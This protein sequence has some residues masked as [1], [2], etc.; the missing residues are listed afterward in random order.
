PPARPR[1]RRGAGVARREPLRRRDRAVDARRSPARSQRP[2]RRGAARGGAVEARDPAHARPAPG[3]GAPGGRALLLR[4]HDAERDRPRA[5]HLRV[6]R[7]PGPQPGDGPH[8]PAPHQGDALG[9]RP[10]MTPPPERSRASAP[11]ERRSDR[12]AGKTPGLHVATA[13]AEVPAGP[14]ERR[15]ASQSLWSA[16]EAL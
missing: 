6:A 12:A 5:R 1:A 9:P 11:L 2:G 8:A 15:R 7:L 3:A 10:P 14:V 4:A 16:V 13:P